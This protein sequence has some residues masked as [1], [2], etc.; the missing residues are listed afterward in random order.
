MLFPTT[1]KAGPKRREPR[2]VL[3]MNGPERVLNGFRQYVDEQEIPQWEALEKLMQ[4][5]KSV[6]LIEIK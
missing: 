4:A 1:M 2:T 5:A 3:T 6:E